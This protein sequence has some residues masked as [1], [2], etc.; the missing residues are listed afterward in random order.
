MLLR[1]VFSSFDRD[2]DGFVTAADLKEAAVG[3]PALT[4]ALAQ[5]VV[6]EVDTDGDGRI[7]VDEFLAALEPD[8]VDEADA[9]QESINLEARH[10]ELTALLEAHSAPTSSSPGPAESIAALHDQVEVARTEVRTLEDAL[11]RERARVAP[12]L[13]QVE[14]SE[15]KMEAFED[16]RKMVLE[17]HAVL[18]SF[19]NAL[20]LE[21]K[22]TG[23]LQSALSKEQ[24]RRTLLLQILRHFK[25][26]L[27]NGAEPTYAMP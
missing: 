15:Q 12:L 16:M 22:D 27:L 25:A 7:S 8:D 13:A 18:D 23:E 19:Q 6:Q 26:Q 20:E 3:G 14:D 1:Q 24:T 11:E 17:S 5:L 10:R 4:D 21:R 2:N 9:S